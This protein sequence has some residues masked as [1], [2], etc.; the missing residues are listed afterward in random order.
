MS[1][2]RRT[3]PLLVAL[4][5]WALLAVAAAPHAW[6]VAAAAAGFVVEM[7]ARRLGPVALVLEA[8]ALV[9]IVAVAP[10]EKLGFVFLGA[11]LAVA[12][13]A[14]ARALGRPEDG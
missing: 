8:L 10:G 4:W 2:L 9:V 11:G 6:A 14:I 7:L 1:Q 5:G 3:G 12:A 13:R